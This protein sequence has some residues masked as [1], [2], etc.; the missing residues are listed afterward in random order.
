MKR[1]IDFGQV[2]WAEKTA[3]RMQGARYAACL[4]EVPPEPPAAGVIETLPASDLARLIEEG[5]AGVPAAPSDLLLRRAAR[6]RV[7]ETLAQD[8]DCLSQ[9]EHTLVEQMLIVGDAVPLESVPALEAALTLRLRLWC[10]VGLVDGEPHA[11]LDPKIAGLLPDQMMTR[12]HVERRT[13]VFALDGMLRAMLYMTGFLDDR[14]PRRRFIESV[15]EEAETPENARLARNFLEASYDC[16]HL[17]GCNLLLHDALAAPEALVGLLAS[18]GALQFP[19]IS[20]EQMLG[21]MNELLPE[22]SVPHEKLCRALFGALRPEYDAISVAHELRML[23]KQGAPL[24][25]LRE[26]MA[27]KLCVLPTP[28]MLGALSELHRQ[29]PRWVTPTQAAH[30]AKLG[31]LH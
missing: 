21:S 4:A 28:H 14:L 26:V 5:W 1:Y 30:A 16:C 22:E 19:I 6:R 15:L 25:A 13:R 12:R 3:G 7:T 31:V 10:D 18:Q 20:P 17:S 29:S 2:G 8:A 23:A 27:E 24:C 9:A 11:R